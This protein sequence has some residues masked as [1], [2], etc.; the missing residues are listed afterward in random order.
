MD[1]PF[2]CNCIPV[3]VHLDCVSLIPLSAGRSAGGY[4]RLHNRPDRGTRYRIP[5]SD[6]TPPFAGQRD[7]QSLLPHLDTLDHN[8]PRNER[9]LNLKTLGGRNLRCGDV[10]VYLCFVYVFVPCQE[11]SLLLLV[12]LLLMY[13]LGLGLRCIKLREYYSRF[14]FPHC[15]FYRSKQ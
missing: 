14:Y 13:W 4:Q 6:S 10:C 12:V 5:M 9:I 2:S 8:D 7:F 1:K 15:R 3:G 11:R